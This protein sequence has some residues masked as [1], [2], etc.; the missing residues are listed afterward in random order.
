MKLKAEGRQIW[1]CSVAFIQAPDPVKPYLFFH[2][3]YHAHGAYQECVG[4]AT[5]LKFTHYQL[6]QDE[7]KNDAEVSWGTVAHQPFSQ[8]LSK[9]SIEDQQRINTFSKLNNRLRLVFEK[10][11]VLRVCGGHFLSPSQVD[12][13][14][15]KA[16]ARSPRRSVD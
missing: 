9:L 11:K 3:I 15:S 7:E 4:R 1:I 10:L 5:T 13:S 2:T 8:C 16:R 6:E 12:H 14:S